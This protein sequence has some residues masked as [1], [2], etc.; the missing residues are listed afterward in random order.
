M[1][2]LHMCETMFE[3]SKG[4]NTMVASVSLQKCKIVLESKYEVR[5]LKNAK[6]IVL[7]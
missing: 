6:I 3:K 1:D 4:I 7:L 2:A 5:Y